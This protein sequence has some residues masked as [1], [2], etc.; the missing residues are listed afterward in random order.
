MPI[1]SVVVE[2]I[3]AFTK[4]KMEEK[5]MSSSQ[6]LDAEYLGIVTT[7]KSM[8][9]KRKLRYK[10]VAEKTGFPESSLK[11]IFSG[12]DCSIRTLMRICECLDTSLEEV[13]KVDSSQLNKGFTLNEE[14]QQLFVRDPKIYDMFIRMV[15]KNEN[16]QIRQD[17]KIDQLTWRRY[18]KE[19]EDVSLIERHADD[20]AKLKVEGGLKI[21]GGPLHD[22]LV[23]RVSEKFLKALPDLHK[24]DK[25]T[26]YE[27]GSVRV[28]R[29]LFEEFSFSLKNLHR[30][31]DRRS[32]LESTLLENKDLNKVTYIIAAAEFD[33]IKRT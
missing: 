23:G 33:S 8:L 17:L 30:D 16:T 24:S 11:K 22:F 12:R 21:G 27:V 18:L 26:V 15:Q 20:T 1:G 28:T 2:A 25:E 32:N 14:Q 5:T 7:L 6:H 3:F 4:I 10:D 19:L 9:K 29:R 31:F 13:L